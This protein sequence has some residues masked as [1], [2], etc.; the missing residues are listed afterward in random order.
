[1]EVLGFFFHKADSVYRVSLFSNTL[2]LIPPP[3]LPLSFSSPEVTL[4][5]VSVCFDLVSQII[6]V[7]KGMVLPGKLPV[8]RVLPSTRKSPLVGSP[9]VS[10]PLL[11]FLVLAFYLGS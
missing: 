6:H 9:A 11:L 2:F 4:Q 1:V 5:A 8:E 10:F 3:S 7:F